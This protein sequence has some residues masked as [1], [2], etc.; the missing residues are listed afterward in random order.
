MRRLL[1]V[2][3]ALGVAGTALGAAWYLAANVSQPLTPTPEDKFECDLPA[4]FGVLNQATITKLPLISGLKNIS[5]IAFWPE[6]STEE[7][8]VFVVVDDHEDHRLFGV[9]LTKK[10]FAYEVKIE[11]I[12]I[13]KDIHNAEGITYL[14]G[15][16]F[17]IVEERRQRAIVFSVNPDTLLGKTR[18]FTDPLDG[19]RFRDLCKNNQRRGDPLHYICNSGLEG[20][21]FDGGSRLYFIQEKH[22]KRLFYTE[23]TPLLTCGQDE[24]KKEKDVTFPEIIEKTWV[25]KS[26]Q[27]SDLA[28]LVALPDERLLLLSQECSAVI[29]FDIN[30]APYSVASFHD[31]DLDQVEGLTRDKDGHIFLVGEGGENGTGS[32][33]YELTLPNNKLTTQ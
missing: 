12:P 3:L 13:D 23:V 28:D 11:P 26:E 7:K 8:R 19:G 33:F 29:E 2:A 32:F 6:A 15:N 9:T 1:Q 5:G 10:D 16:R 22:P 20:I 14:G 17:A 21:S 4:A 27:F 24:A 18:C 30:G 31:T 25:S